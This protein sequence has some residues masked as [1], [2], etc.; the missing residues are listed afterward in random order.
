MIKEN[1]SFICPIFC[2]EKRTDFFFSEICSRSKLIY[3]YNL[4]LAS[5][6]CITSGYNL[7]SSFS[8]QIYCGK[9]NFQYF[10]TEP[11]I[12]GPALPPPHTSLT[13]GGAA[14]GP[15][16]KQRI[17]MFCRISGMGG[18]E[19]HTDKTQDF[20]HGDGNAPRP[21]GPPRSRSNRHDCVPHRGT[22]DFQEG[23]WNN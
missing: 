23:R 13:T 15:S 5:I 8:I 3:T 11:V 22:T 19:G 6:K 4:L 10:D 21:S 2:G 1:T 14:V 18:P 17:V 16:G 20:Q 9:H 12:I 7:L